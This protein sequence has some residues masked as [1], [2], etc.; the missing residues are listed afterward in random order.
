MSKAHALVVDDETDILD[1]V[2]ITLSRMG[3]SCRTAE[4]IDQ[5]KGLLAEDRFDLCLTDMR[6]PDDS[7]TSLVRHIAE[8][9][10]ELPVAVIT[11][12][13]NMESAVEAMK[14]GAFDCVSKPVDL[15]LLRQL[16]ESA[17]RLGSSP[18]RT[19]QARPA[20][21][22][23]RLLGESQPIYAI[24]RLIGKLSRN[25][26]PV[27]ISGESG[28]GKEL[29][30]RLV[31]EQGPRAGA[32]FVPVNCGAIPQDLVEGELFG[33][34]K[35]SF[36][37]AVNDKLGLFQ[38]ADGGT[39]FLDEIADLPLSTQVKLLRVIQEKSVRPIGSLHEAPVDVRIISAT[40]HD[41]AQEVEK[42]LFRQDL[43]YRINV[44]ELQMPPLRAHPQ[45]IPLLANHVLERIAGQSDAIP[46]TLTGRALSALARYPFPGNVREL[47]NILERAVALT[48]DGTIDAEDLYLPESN[49]SGI[50]HPEG[51]EKA[52]S[53]EKAPP[54][55]PS[56]RQPLGDYLDELEKQAILRALEETRW[57]RTAAAKKLG[58][59]L[60]SLRYRLSKLSIE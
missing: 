30:A 45:D 27:Y 36:T 35:G 47:E 16:V 59:T 53:P 23:S 48:D 12:H 46:R 28:T 44:I 38:A 43:F 32:A 21:I 20:S 31:H 56:I 51:P 50:I 4:T 33:H 29:A 14:A 13:G 8:V 57:N 26:A 11:A 49:N 42:G 58:M 55:T 18:G 19:G 1:L 52:P 40:H 15:E 3:I 25:Q 6:L 2:R 39:L 7:G 60:R 37:G 9:C 22:Q 5:A 17:L 10:P 41:L 34:K 54:L 24:R